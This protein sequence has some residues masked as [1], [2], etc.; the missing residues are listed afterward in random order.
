MSGTQKMIV[1]LVAIFVA[2]GV[3]VGAI[4]LLGGSDDSSSAVASYAPVAQQTDSAGTYVPPP[5]TGQ[6]VNQQPMQADRPT[7]VRANVQSGNTVLLR[8]NASARYVRYFQIYD[9]GRRVGGKV[10]PNQRS[11]L[12]GTSYGTHCFR[13]VAVAVASASSSSA[14]GCGTV[15]VAKPYQP[16]SGSYNPPPGSYNPPPSGSNNPPPSDS[17]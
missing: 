12:L 2:A 10:P 4:V 1:A 9:N 6:P 3:I 13:V 15:S 5:V 8:W 16:P 11:V 17:A 14:S 7:G